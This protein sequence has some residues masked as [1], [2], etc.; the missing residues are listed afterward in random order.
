MARRNI[1]TRSL[2][3]RAE[4][5][6]RENRFSDAA[7][8]YRK[9]CTADRADVDAQVMLAI[10]KVH[11]GEYQEALTWALQ[12]I[13]V[14]PDHALA[15][16]ALGTAYQRQGRLCEAAEE[17]HQAI[18]LRPRFA[19]AHF[20]LANTLADQGDY[21]AAEMSYL[22]ALDLERNLS[23]AMAGLGRLYDRTGRLQEAVN[24]FQKALEIEPECAEFLVSL[25]N[26]LSTQGKPG[27]A[28]TVLQKAVLLEPRSYVA[29]YS[30]GSLLTTL[31][32]YDDATEYYRTACA[33]RPEDEYAVGAL[34]SILERRSNFEEAYRLLKP[35]V[36]A[37]STNPGIAVPFAALAKHFGH[38]NEAV[39]VLEHALT[40]DALEIKTRTDL[41][42]KLGKL[43]D[44]TEDYEEAFAHYRRGNELTRKLNKSVTDTEAIDVIAE[45]I[46]RQAE[47]CDKA[48]WAALPRASNKSTQPVFVV[49]MPRSGTTL[50]EHILASH[51]KI[52]GAGELSGIETIARSLARSTA[53]SPG[54]PQALRD[55]PF[56][57]I[58]REA[59]RHLQRLLA[60]SRTAERVV[61][62]YPHNFLYLGLI[63]LLFPKAHIIHISRDP[64]DTCLSIYFQIFAPQHGY[65]CDLD[66]LG[67][68]YRTYQKIMRY[69]GDVL[70]IRILDIEYEQLLTTPEQTI[71]SLIDFCGLSWD[72]RCLQFYETQRDVNTPSYDQVRQPL[73]LGSIG[74]WQHYASQ[75]H[76]LTT[77]L[78]AAQPSE[79]DMPS[80]DR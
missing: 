23:R 11:T 58:D 59:S 76:E 36:A 43:L 29:N 61:D 28:L 72:E 75:I 73:Y 77:A 14:S 3:R 54:Y 63:S 57:L 17:F 60:L 26:S 39:R 80:T 64:R 49:G 16:H 21:A 15:H 74:R 4:T 2:K 32:R 52:H 8:L 69:W 40:D 22:K 12:A 53:D 31:G 35:F 45:D 56:H 47:S 44:A 5:L 20:F 27:E 30:I 13:K 9:L 38:H 25:G 48:F 79:H 33:L 42:F 19:N 50:L 10:A 24:C 18:R 6:F 68:H 51:P 62:K 78:Q 70:D 7:G 34:A 37:G 55:T 67:K 41:H 71:R 46:A 65:A 66:R 1:L